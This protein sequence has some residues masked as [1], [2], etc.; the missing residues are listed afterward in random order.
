MDSAEV[1]ELC[2]CCVLLLQ[3][4]LVKQ[5]E[6]HT[7]CALGDAGGRLFDCIAQHHRKSVQLDMQPFCSCMHY[8]WAAECEHSTNIALQQP[9]W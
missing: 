6:G 3:D 8:C 5:I 1:A 2:C 9:P 4:M 7:I